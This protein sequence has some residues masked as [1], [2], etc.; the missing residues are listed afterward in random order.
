[1]RSEPIFRVDGNMLSMPLLESNKQEEEDEDGRDGTETEEQNDKSSNQL[2]ASLHEL[3]EA[4]KD[5]LRKPC[6]G[7]ELS[8][9]F[10]DNVGKLG[11]DLDSSSDEESSEEDHSEGHDSESDDEYRVLENS[12]DAIERD[13]D[14]DE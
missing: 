13:N 8:Y 11:Y 7:S 9:L 4:N 5:H 2:Y 12:S 14:N 10:G 1:M 6:A 3:I